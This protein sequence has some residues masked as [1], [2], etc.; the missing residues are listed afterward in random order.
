MKI[1]CH[2]NTLLNFYHFITMSFSKNFAPAFTQSQVRH[3]RLYSISI[4]LL[5]KIT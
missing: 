5:L 2:G 1:K 4:I 3:F